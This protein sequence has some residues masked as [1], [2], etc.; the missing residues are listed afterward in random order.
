VTLCKYKKDKVD[1]APVWSIGAHLPLSG[2]EP[3]GG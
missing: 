1:H 3:V 2:R